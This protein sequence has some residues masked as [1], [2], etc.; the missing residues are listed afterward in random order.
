MT[1][2]HSKCASCGKSL[3]LHLL[4][5]KPESLKGKPATWD[6]LCRAAD[7]GADFD[8]L[9]CQ[10]CYGPAWAEGVKC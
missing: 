7:A 5:A 10:T 3:P 2:T 8:V 4:D 9:E 1:I 6:A